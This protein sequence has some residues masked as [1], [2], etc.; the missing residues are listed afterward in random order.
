VSSAAAVVSVLPEQ[1]RP[2]VVEAQARRSGEGAPGLAEAGRRS[3]RRDVR[4]LF[5]R[6]VTVGAA[7]AGR[8]RSVGSCAPSNIFFLR[9]HSGGWPGGS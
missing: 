9:C 8:D 5:E 7:E 6:R 4:T 3:S 2:T 1:R